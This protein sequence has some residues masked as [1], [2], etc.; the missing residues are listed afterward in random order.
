ML[1]KDQKQPMIGGT[2]IK[3]TRGGMSR[4]E[5]AETVEENCIV[6]G[7]RRYQDSGGLTVG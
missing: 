4:N 1:V 2:I 6:S 7:S 5:R 3:A